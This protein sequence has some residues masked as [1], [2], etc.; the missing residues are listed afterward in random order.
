MMFGCHEGVGVSNN[1]NF[2]NDNIN[3]NNNSPGGSIIYTMF[4]SEETEVQI[5]QN[6]EMIILELE[7]AGEEPV[8]VE[9]LGFYISEPHSWDIVEKNLYYDNQIISTN[10][11]ETAGVFFNFQETGVVLDPGEK[12]EFVFKATFVNGVCRDSYTTLLTTSIENRA[13]GVNSGVKFPFRPSDNPIIGIDTKKITGNALSVT[14]GP[15]NPPEGTVMQFS[16]D[17]LLLEV[18]MTAGE[19]VSIDAYNYKMYLSGNQTNLEDFRVWTVNDA[20]EWVVVSGPLDEPSWE[21]LSNYCNVDVPDTINIPKCRDT[22]LRATIDVRN[23]PVDTI[24][25]LVMDTTG[26]EVVSNLTQQQLASDHILADPEV[27][28]NLQWIV[29]YSE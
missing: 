11:A 29:P 7:N 10:T 23:M 24:L 16:N 14:T 5:F 21:C 13:F 12:G 1:N 28:G 2:N 8:R 27:W 17:A 18:M 20:S 3:Q 25:R 4:F 22:I 26:M 9:Q 15:A 6:Q 19:D